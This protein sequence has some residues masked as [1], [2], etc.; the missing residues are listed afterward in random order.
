MKMK[1][2]FF[3]LVSMGLIAACAPE[4][5]VDEI[6]AKQIENMLEKGFT[7]TKAP[8]ALLPKEVTLAAAKTLFAYQEGVWDSKWDWV[9]PEG[10]LLGSVEGVETFTTILDGAVQEILNEVPAFGPNTKA[11]MTYNHV[12]QK[13]IFFSIG[14]KGDYWLMKQNPVTG[15]MVSE[16][17][18]NPDGSSQIIRFTTMRKIDNEMDIIMESSKDGGATW[19]KAFTQYMVRRAGE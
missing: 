13:I 15:N 9:D 8:E 2:A 3:G 12:E 17:H 19:V 4:Q 16:P 5:V 1:S 7:D 14:A 11:V 18:A 10:K 6:A